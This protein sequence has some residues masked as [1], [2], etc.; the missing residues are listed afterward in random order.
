MELTLISIDEREHFTKYHY[1]DKDGS[2]HIKTVWH[3]KK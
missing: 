3:C 1:V 2:V